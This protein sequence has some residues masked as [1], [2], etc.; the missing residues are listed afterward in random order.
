M[1]NVP[2]KLNKLKSKVDKL[3]V[4]KLVPVP[5]DLSKLSDGVKN[6]VV[7]KDV[8]NAKIQII[9]DKIPDITNLATNVSVNAK[10]NGV[11][12]E[13]PSITN[14]A[15]NAFLNAK[16]NEVKDEIPGIT[17]LAT[18]ASLNAKIN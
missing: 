8:Y 1:K 17:N 4:D 5:V 2:T 13:I 10:I 15:T 14:L 12:G 7:K 3:Y 18:N 6:Y 11:T 9:E 16:T